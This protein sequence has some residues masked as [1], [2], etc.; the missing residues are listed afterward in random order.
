VGK[1][2]LESFHKNEP[3]MDAG[4]VLPVDFGFPFQ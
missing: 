4:G 3:D 1:E 2:R